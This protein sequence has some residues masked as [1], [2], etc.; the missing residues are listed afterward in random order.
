M[1]A[2]RDATGA[3]PSFRKIGA[4]SCLS[5]ELLAEIIE[6]IPL[7]VAVDFCGDRVFLNAKARSLWL[8]TDVDSSTL[9][10]MVDGKVQP[11]LALHPVSASDKGPTVVPHVRV[12]GGG[13]YQA[14]MFDW[15]RPPDALAWRVAILR[16]I[17][18]GS[19]EGGFLTD[20]VNRL[21]AIV[22]EFRNTLTAARE[23]LAFMHEGAVGELNAEQ[24]RFLSSAMEDLEGLG[25]AMVDLT[26]LWVTQAG[27]L[28]MMPCPVDIRHIVE[29]TTLGAQPVAEKQGISL[30]IEIGDPPP[31]L[32]GDQKLLVQALRNVLTNAMRHTSAGGEIRVRAFVVDGAKDSAMNSGRAS[33]AEPWRSFGAEESVVIEVHDSGIGIGPADQE[34]VF[35]AFERGNS[36]GSP[37]GS[38]HGGGMGLG[39]AIARDIASR[40]G[41]TLH[42]RSARGEG[43]CFVFRFPKSETCA[44]SWMVR[45]T[46]RAIDD[47]HPLRTPLAGV[48]LRFD[49]ADGHPEERVH[50]D[51]LFALQQVAIENL[52]PTDT[53]LAIEGQLLL[54]IR[55]STRAAARAMIGRVVQSLGKMFRTGGATLGECRMVLG[56]AAYPED[57]DSP[58]AILARAETEATVFPIGASCGTE[59][60]HEREADNPAG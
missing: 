40:H 25:R 48:L 46:Q 21:K 26:S 55:G 15:K 14:V 44:R 7:P 36:D 11:L 51:L 35:E 13:Q 56:V 42:V 24:R 5:R 47:V 54:L 30:R 16:P 27:V 1:A 17:E 50:P 32:T 38:P 29:Q 23:A 34:R 49:T 37:A 6:R 8:A 20:K 58:E 52:R 22:H 10:V 43:S 2:I 57:G 33:D 45:A 59:E 18:R 9:L 28:R 12:P 19:A 3:E 31:I 41:G 4:S 60:S 39:L 53:V